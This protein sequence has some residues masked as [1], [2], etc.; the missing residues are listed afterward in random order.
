MISQFFATEISCGSFGVLAHASTKLVWCQSSQA[1]FAGTQA[2]AM[3][4]R[5]AQNFLM[6]ALVWADKE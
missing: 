1:T 4:I 6:L 5:V 2:R 3:V